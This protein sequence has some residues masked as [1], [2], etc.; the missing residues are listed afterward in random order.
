[1]TRIDRYEQLVAWQFAKELADLVEKLVTSGAAA[2]NRSFQD[3]ILRSS[4]KP[5]AQIAEGFLRFLP[6]ES[7]YYY[8]IARA[9]LGET[10]NHLLRGFQRAYWTE[11]Q[12]KEASRLAEIAMKTTGGLLASR[13]AAI[14]R[15]ERERQERRQ[16]RAGQRRA[17]A[18]AERNG[19]NPERQ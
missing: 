11:A 3:Q 10:K 13:L 19:K 4:A 14:R 7:A 6:T 1:M 18:V 16:A 15:Q 5:P 9:S 17:P 8:R 12:F 2:R